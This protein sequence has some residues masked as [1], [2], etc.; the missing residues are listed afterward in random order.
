MKLDELK[1]S[2]DMDEQN[3]DSH[4][5]LIQELVVPL[6]GVQRGQLRRKISSLLVSV[7]DA[8]ISLHL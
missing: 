1:L 6:C 7:I 2:N 4:L 3:H 8:F 5:R